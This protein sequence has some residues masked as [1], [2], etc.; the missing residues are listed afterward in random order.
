[1]TRATHRHERED[2]HGRRFAGFQHTPRP[3]EIQHQHRKAQAS[4]VATPGCDQFEVVTGQGEVARDLAFIERRIKMARQHVAGQ[5]VSSG[6]GRTPPCRCPSDVRWTNTGNVS[7]NSGPSMAIRTGSHDDRKTDTLGR[8]MALI[9]YA[10]VSTPDQKLSLQQDALERAGCERIFDDQASGARTD[11]PG[12]APA[13]P[14]RC[15][16]S[17]GSAA[18]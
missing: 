5:Q 17:I 13:T 1:M 7:V 12:L 14:W 18:R 15:G 16:S 10:R 8:P 4:G 3:A 9:G 6:Q 2:R 11:R